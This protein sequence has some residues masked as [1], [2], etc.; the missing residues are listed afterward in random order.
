MS[1]SVASDLDTTRPSRG[2]A[3]KRLA[4]VAVKL[5]VTAA[6]FWYLSRQID[7][8]QVL[9]AVRVLDFHWAAFAT[10]VVV[11]QIPLM[12]L[13]WCGIVDELAARS[14]RITLTIM[15]AVTAI[16]IFLAQVLPSVAGE[17]V[18]AWLLARR[19][20]DWRNA[21]ISVVIDR[22]VGAALVIALGFVILLFP[23]SLTALGGY[24]EAV[25]VVYGG[26]LFAGALGLLVA[27]QMAALLGRWPYSR[28]LATL[29]AA[30][31]RVLVGPRGAV[32]LALGCFIHALTIVVVWAL[33]R[34]Q[35][36]MLPITDAAVL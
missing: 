32:I 1:T 36:F 9:S 12:G 34:A 17:G 20:Y 7:T 13:R 5:L 6:C 14:K 29:A 18:R 30:T 35:G 31:R 22:G 16:G 33:G 10:V 28:W 8:G 2:G 3:T 24:R 4:I 25:L 19:G 27:P 23:S 21:V 15:V 11:L 26:L